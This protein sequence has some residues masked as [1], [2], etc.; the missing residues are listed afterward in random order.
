MKKFNFILLI[1]I[2]SYMFWFSASTWRS[3]IA[4]EWFNI[5]CWYI[6]TPVLMVAVYVIYLSGR[7]PTFNLEKYRKR[8]NN[9]GY[10]QRKASFLAYIIPGFLVMVIV[11][12]IY[13]IP[14]IPTKLYASHKFEKKVEVIEVTCYG[15]FAFSQNI[16][17]E[18]RCLDKKTNERYSLWYPVN[19]CRIE[20]KIQNLGGKT[21]KLIG[22]SWILGTYIDGFYYPI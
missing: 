6:L 1:L 13:L 12:S 9:L 3:Y 15:Y 5:I 19:L 20:P 10:N 11:W 4:P 18:I 17:T 21:I 2:V 16:S 22:R 7:L 8:Y 14:V